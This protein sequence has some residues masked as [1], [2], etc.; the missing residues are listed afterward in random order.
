VTPA[1]S[2]ALLALALGSCVIL[3]RPLVA[4]SNDVSTILVL[5]TR[6]EGPFRKFARHS[7]LA[8]RPQG[9]TPWTIWECCSPGSHTRDDPFVPS[10]GDEVIL[11]GVIRGERADAAIPCIAAAT[12]RYGR[13]S[14]VFY[15]GPNSNTYVDAVLRACGLHVDLPATAV[16]KDWRGWVGASWTSGGTGVQLETPLVGLAVGLGEGIVLHVFSLSIGV[17][18]WPPAIILPVG[19]GRFGFA[20]R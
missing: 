15:P 1:R 18:L 5:T 19:G 7:Y 13:P 2:L 10:F 11:H 17:D 6:L 12:E 20:D 9:V 14:Y 4:P 16:G 3:P 8:V